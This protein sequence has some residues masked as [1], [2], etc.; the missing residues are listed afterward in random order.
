MQTRVFD[1]DGHARGNQRQQALV[2]F[3]EIARL[4]CF[5]VD[6]ADQAILD[7]QRDSEFRMHVGN[8]LNVKLLARYIVNQLRLPRLS[9]AAG[10]PLAYF[11]PNALGYFGRVS[12]LEAHIQ[13]LPLLVEQ[14]N[15][16][17]FVVD[18]LADEFG[19]ATES[20]FEIERSVNDVGH[21]EQKR[22]RL[23]RAARRCGRC[24]FHRLA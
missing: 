6:N 23:G 15:G 9:R 24:R 19:D 18:D 10:N 2:L 3:G 16:E 14:E 7:D 12:D 8:R 20:S 22:L 13:F 1:P 11:Y 5:D 4:A 17:D 21:L